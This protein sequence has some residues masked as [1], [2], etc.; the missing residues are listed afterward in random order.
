MARLCEDRSDRA[1]ECIATSDINCGQEGGARE[2][3]GARAILNFRKKSMPRAARPLTLSSRV[4]IPAIK[5]ILIA[6][7]NYFE[8]ERALSL[9]L[10]LLPIAEY[11][12]TLFYG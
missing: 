4:E 8:G 6:P 12:A 9:S 7:I 2:K 1:R 11:M 10:S 3:N 5:Y